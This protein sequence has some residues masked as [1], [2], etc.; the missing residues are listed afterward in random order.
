MQIVT[1][2]SVQHDTNVS[3][4]ARMTGVVAQALLGYDMIQRML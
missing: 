4:Q 3:V 1:A 2:V